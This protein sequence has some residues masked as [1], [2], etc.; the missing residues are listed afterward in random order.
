MDDGSDCGGTTFISF[1]KDSGGDTVVI[2]FNDYSP[3]LRTQRFTAER[4]GLLHDIWNLRAVD[5]MKYQGTALLDNYFWNQNMPQRPFFLGGISC[6]KPGWHILFSKGM[7]AVAVD[8]G[9]TILQHLGIVVIQ[10]LDDIPE[11]ADQ[12]HFIHMGC[13]AIAVVKVPVI[14]FPHRIVICGGMPIQPSVSAATVGAADLV[15]E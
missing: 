3:L 9:N 6:G 4:G 8:G 13:L 11:R 15:G 12:Q 14:T 2:C 10:N 5:D 1:G 7:L